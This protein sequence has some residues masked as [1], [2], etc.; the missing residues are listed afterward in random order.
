MFHSFIHHLSMCVF[1]F[2]VHKHNIIHTKGSQKLRKNFPQKG[3]L[4]D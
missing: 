1:L 3:I 4:T 2:R